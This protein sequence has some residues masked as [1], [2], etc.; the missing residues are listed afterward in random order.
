MEVY[1]QNIHMTSN[2][3]SQTR[4]WITSFYLH[5]LFACC[6]QFNPP[7][8]A[9]PAVDRAIKYENVD[10]RVCVCACNKNSS[11]LREQKRSQSKRAVRSFLCSGPRVESAEHMSNIALSYIRYTHLKLSFVDV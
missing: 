5:F 2:L 7:V 6:F 11:K 1:V 3:L 8:F 9:A 4:L 10:Q